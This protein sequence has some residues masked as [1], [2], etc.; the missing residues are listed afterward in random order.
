MSQMVKTVESGKTLPPPALNLLTGIQELTGE[1]SRVLFQ[2]DRSEKRFPL[3]VVVYKKPAGLTGKDLR[4]GIEV[5][6]RDGLPGFVGTGF[7]TQGIEFRTHGDPD[8]T[9]MSLTEGRQRIR[10]RDGLVH[11]RLSPLRRSRFHEGESDTALRYS[12]LIQ[13]ITTQLGEGR[14]IT[15][16]PYGRTQQES[17][18]VEGIGKNTWRL[19]YMVNSP[20]AAASLAAPGVSAQQPLMSAE[21]SPDGA[22]RLMI[23]QQ[24]RGVLGRTNII[25]TTL[26]NRA[27]PMEFS[28]VA[29]HII[30]REPG[31]K[32]YRRLDLRTAGELAERLA[33][34]DITTPHRK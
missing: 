1:R 3:V 2:P 15:L 13:A 34:F 12:R 20:E 5:G 23:T 27:R 18:F 32:K 10:S 31:E 4:L 25:H 21:F 11:D 33:S 8:R 17:E 22:D 6:M 16:D 24:P 28:I 29:G 14:D 26:P 7:P 9:T 30:E 19:L